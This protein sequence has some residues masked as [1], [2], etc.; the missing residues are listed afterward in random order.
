MKPLTIPIIVH[1]EYTNKAIDLDLNYSLED[2]AIEDYIF[3]N[4]NL[5]S[6]YKEN[7]KEYTM[8]CCN[9]G[10]DGNKFLRIFDNSKQ[11]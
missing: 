5:I 9:P 10:V 7:G 6:P 3:Y 11:R 1:T 8:I 4:I 2:C